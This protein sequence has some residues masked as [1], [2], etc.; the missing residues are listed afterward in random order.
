MK[1]W[2]Y[3]V[4]NWLDARLSL[5]ASRVVGRDRGK[6]EHDHGNAEGG[7]RP[8]AMP[9][10]PRTILLRSELRGAEG[11]DGSAWDADSAVEA[12]AFPGA[13][14]MGLGECKVTD[15]SAGW[16]IGSWF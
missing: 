12:A 5:R 13:V 6:G 4:G 3:S 15:C 10:M 14:G 11:G 8:L 2:L 7:R 9:T 1:R 16:P